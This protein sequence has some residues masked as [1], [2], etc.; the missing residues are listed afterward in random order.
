MVV[1]EVPRDEL[2]DEPRTVVEEVPREE[3]LDEPLTDEEALPRDAEEPVRTLLLDEEPR[4][5]DE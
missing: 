2:L 1:E 4:E 3:L 5:E